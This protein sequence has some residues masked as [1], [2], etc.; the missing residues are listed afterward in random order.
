MA[1]GQVVGQPN[2]WGFDDV[3]W[4]TT[5]VDYYRVQDPAHGAGIPCGLTGYQSMT[6]SCPSGSVTYT[7]SFG[8]KL[9][10]TTEQTD[11]I[12]CRYDMNNSVC[13]TINY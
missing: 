5:A 3:G 11:V 12:N 2:H 6:K 13:Q 8:N 7:P 4:T 10:A 1:G 9:T